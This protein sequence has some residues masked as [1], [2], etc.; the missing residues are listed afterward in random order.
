MADHPAWR[1]LPSPST[2]RPHDP[3]VLGPFT[4]SFVPSRADRRVQVPTAVRPSRCCRQ[5]IL[6]HE[7]PRCSPIVAVRSHTEDC[8]RAGALRRA[9]RE[10]NR[11]WESARPSFNTFEALFTWQYEGSRLNALA[12]FAGY[13]PAVRCRRAGWLTTLVRPAKAQSRT[14]GGTMAGP[15]LGS[16][17]PRCEGDES[18]G[19]ILRRICRL[20]A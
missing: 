5:P 9:G 19:R 14:A 12:R 13:K 3:C 18:P 6:R 4:F 7:N 1:T 16:G 8:L 15:V 2:P 20:G 17:S 11:L 10:C